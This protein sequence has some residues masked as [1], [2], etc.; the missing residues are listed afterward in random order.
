MENVSFEKEEEVMKKVLALVAIVVLSSAVAVA[1]V[2]PANQASGKIPAPAT[3]TNGTLGSLSIT[4]VQSGPLQVLIDASVT[5]VGGDGVPFVYTTTGGSVYNLDDQIYLYGQ[6]YDS[7]WQGGCTSWA[8]PGPNWCDYAG[9]YFVNSPTPLNSF[10]VSFTS[11]VPA[12]DDYQLFA[13]AYAGV[14]WP[15][16]GFAW[17]FISQSP[18]IGP[19]G[20][21]YI[22]STQVPTPTP[23]PAVAG[24]P[25]PT[26][27]LIGI[28]AMIAIMAGIAIFVMVGRK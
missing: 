21:M 14:T 10:A 17:G 7:P 27:N 20:T 9:Q 26:L 1:N 3:R 6:I 19:V 18:Y 16:T 13:I 8:T 25:V 23:P 22:G 11:T 5:T 4:G 15:T 12:A 24:E 28:L 2:N